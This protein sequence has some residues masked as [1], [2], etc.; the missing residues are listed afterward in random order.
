MLNFKLDKKCESCSFSHFV[1]LCMP[2]AM[3]TDTR[4]FFV[5]DQIA[6]IA[7]IKMEGAEITSLIH[8]TG[9]LG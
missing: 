5:A 1:L 9:V 4:Q 7:F 2:F 8:C 3:A 6:F